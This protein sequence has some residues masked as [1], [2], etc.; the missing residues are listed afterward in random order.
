MASSL[1]N[2]IKKIEGALLMTKP[3]TLK[4][5]IGISPDDWGG[6]SQEGRSY[7]SFATEEDYLKYKAII[8]PVGCK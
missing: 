2:R 7:I 5:Y 6:P 3:S 1:L 4:A 8:R